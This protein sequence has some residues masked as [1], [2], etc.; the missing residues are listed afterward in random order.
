M[1]DITA[2]FYFQRLIIND[3]IDDDDG[4]EIHLKIA[5]QKNE[6]EFFLMKKNINHH[7]NTI[8]LH[9]RNIFSE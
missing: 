4:P 6:N 2:N 1:D 7:H 8:Q 5:K 3:D 9:T